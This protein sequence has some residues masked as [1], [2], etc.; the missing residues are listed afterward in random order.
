MPRQL[1]VEAENNFSGGLVTQGTGLNFP[2]NSCTE[3][4]NCIHH[5]L[6]NIKR[7]PGF[8]FEDNFTV[9]TIDRTSSA[10]SNF[11]WRN[12]SGDGTVNLEVLQVGETLYFYL[13]SSAGFSAGALATTVDLTD[14]MPA[15]APSPGTSECQYAPGLGHLFVTHPTLEPFYITYDEALE[16]VSTV[17]ITVKIRDTEGIDDSLDIDERPTVET[18]AHKYNLYNQGWYA[19]TYYAQWFA[20]RAD[21]PS[22][23][24][25]WWLFKN[26]DDQFDLTTVS[27]VL[28]DRGT[29]QSARGHYIL[30]AFNQDRSTVS[31]IASLT[32]VDSGYQRP[33]ACAF[34]SGRI[35]YAGVASNGF[36]SKLYFSQILLNI[37][38]AGNCYSR[39]DPSSEN[40]DQLQADDGGWLIIP[41]IGL[42]R[43]LVPLGSSLIVFGSQG[44]F[45]IT[46]STGIG[47]TALDYSVNQIS[48]VKCLSAS[49]FVDVDGFPSF[50][51][52]EGI[53]AVLPGQSGN[54]L[55]VQSLTDQKIKEYYL[56]IPL[57]CKRLARGAYDP[58]SHTIQWLFRSAEPASL[59][60]AYEFTDVLNFNT[61]AGGF[62]PWTLP[63]S[64]VTVNGIFLSEGF[65]ADPD[66]RQVV[67]GANNVVVG[68][69]NVAT[70]S[71]GDLVLEFSNKFIVSYPESSTYKF[72]FA[73]FANT[74]FLDWLSYDDV[75]EDAEATFTVGYKIPTQ[76]AKRFNPTYLYLFSDLRDIDETDFYFQSVWNFSNSGNSGKES[77]RQRITHTTG[78]FDIVRNRLKVRGSGY[79]VQY[80]YTSI[81]SK[82]FNILGW[83]VSDTLATRD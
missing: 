6:G 60:Q 54:N 68:A 36:E 5:E 24:D 28:Y 4:I 49:S 50:W 13:P 16:T 21:Y 27:S 30:E 67:V 38:D 14:F 26:F 25:T 52:I 42:I 33:S 20:S 37:E 31:G 74:S 40:Y 43:K 51:T 41:G 62:Y 53:Y 3:T 79:V 76:G 48:S 82:P 15:G 81:P 77:S 69:N 47:F 23:A 75:G 18:N 46:G 32:V 66:I 12:V 7:R 11:F 58:R 22:N 9:K 73:D 83:T 71:F 10:V 65:G 2:P 55:Q 45:Q 80:R 78:N 19:S 70:I 72:T 39:E 61:I 34:Y 1:A 64:D 59:T 8:D 44:I 56:D 29:T 63:D 57:N 35:W 17:Q